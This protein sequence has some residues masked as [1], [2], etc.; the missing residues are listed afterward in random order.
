[1][2]VS[3]LVTIIRH[4]WCGANLRASCYVTSSV[5]IMLKGILVGRTPMEDLSR[6]ERWYVGG[7][8]HLI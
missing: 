2:L 3:C 8:W 4:R 5:D 6:Y 1:M 7:E